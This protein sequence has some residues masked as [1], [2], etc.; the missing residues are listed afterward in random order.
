MGKFNDNHLQVNYWLWGLMIIV[1][2]YL[3]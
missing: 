1:Y 2:I 3:M